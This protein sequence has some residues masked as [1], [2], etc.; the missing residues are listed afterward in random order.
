MNCFLIKN[1]LLKLK[2]N[3]IKTILVFTV[4]ITFNIH[5]QENR[6]KLK[7]QVQYDSTYLPDINILNKA[8][9]LGTSSDAEG[10]FLINAKKGDSLLFSSL[11]YENRVIKITET[12]LKSKSITAYLEPSFFQLDEIMLNTELVIDWRK[13]SVTKGTIL[14]NDNI[15]NQKAPNARKLTDP[16]ANAGGLNPIALFMELTKKGRL[17]RK[18]KRKKLKSE[19][20]ET[21][22]LKMEFPNKIK[23]SYGANFF[24]DWLSISEDNIYL[25]L[26]YCEGNGLL[27]LYDKNEIVIKDF[28]IKQ[29]KKFNSIQN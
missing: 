5:A 7:G 3:N 15:T 14:N 8:T 26:D 2:I 12:H 19:Q 23:N 22:R 28:L 27:E 25:F 17:K 16:N 13:A 1:F 21:Q 10:R 9:E 6:T 29:A 20:Q 18:A 11:I 4:C 24:I